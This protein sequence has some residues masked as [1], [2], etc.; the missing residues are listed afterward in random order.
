[1]NQDKMKLEYKLNEAV[2]LAPKVYGGKNDDIEF[3]KVK[4]LKKSCYI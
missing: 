4:G 2:F 3:T 1:M